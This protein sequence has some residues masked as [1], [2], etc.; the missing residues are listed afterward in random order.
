[1]KPSRETK[2]E[3]GD[4]P[5]SFLTVSINTLTGMSVKIIRTSVAQRC[6]RI[7]KSSLG[8]FKMRLD[9]SRIYYKNVKYLSVIRVI[10]D[11]SVIVNT[12]I[13]AALCGNPIFDVI[14]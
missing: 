10:D 6:C 8:S 2:N 14:V 5:T 1:M 12:F 4:K 13:F 9:K 7:E 3:V 11:S